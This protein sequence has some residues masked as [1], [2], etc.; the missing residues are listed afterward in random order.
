MC[1][2]INTYMHINHLSQSHVLMRQEREGCMCVA[3]VIP[4]RQMACFFVFFCFFFRKH[5]FFFFPHLFWSSLIPPLPPAPLVP[6]LSSFTLSPSSHLS[7]LCFYSLTCAFLFLH[8]FNSPWPLTSPLCHLKQDSLLS[9]NQR[10][11]L[12]RSSSV[13]TR[14]F[15]DVVPLTHVLTNTCR[16]PCS[17]VISVAVWSVR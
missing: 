8:L 14:V 4:S 13:S 5:T 10:R 16:S 7:N 3:N 15:C 6:A 1:R 9:V 17:A 11:S 2:H 12:L